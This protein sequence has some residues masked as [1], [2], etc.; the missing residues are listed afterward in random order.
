M[1]VPPPGCPVAYPIRAWLWVSEFPVGATSV[2]R[3]T[4]TPS[5]PCLS[6]WQATGGSLPE[7]ATSSSP[8]GTE[9]HVPYRREA[10]WIDRLFV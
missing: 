10:P 1:R 7:R 3:P 8:H 4:V 6:Q 2:L 9:A 5:S